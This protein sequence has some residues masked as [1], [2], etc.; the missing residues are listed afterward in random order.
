MQLTPILAIITNNEYYHAQMYISDYFPKFRAF[1]YLFLH[2]VKLFSHT[3]THTHT[4]ILL[5]ALL[6]I[7]CIG[8]VIEFSLKTKTENKNI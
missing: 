7:W 4:L 1:S 5:E 8:L 6:I 3:C 2:N